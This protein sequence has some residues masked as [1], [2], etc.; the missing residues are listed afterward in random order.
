[1]SGLAIGS[2]RPH[3]VKAKLGSLGLLAPAEYKLKHADS[4]RNEI[5]YR[6]LRLLDAEDAV[7]RADAEQHLFPPGEFTDPPFLSLFVRLLNRKAVMDERAPASWCL[8]TGKREGQT[9]TLFNA[10]RVFQDDV[11]IDI[12]HAAPL[13]LLKSLANTFG[14]EVVVGSTAGRKFILYER[15]PPGEP[16]LTAKVAQRFALEFLFRKTQDGGAEVAVAYGIDMARYR[17]S[18][19]RHK[20]DAPEMP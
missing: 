7:K 3:E 11:D 14:V 6:G 8:V 10:W 16:L 17:E 19:L 4:L 9:L 20:I 15:L 2:P 18:L 1:V 5:K 13:D 12:N